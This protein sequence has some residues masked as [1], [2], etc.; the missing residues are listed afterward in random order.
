MKVKYEYKDG[1]IQ[2]G[3]ID[4]IFTVSYIQT[5]QHKFCNMISIFY[6]VFMIFQYLLHIN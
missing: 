4:G 3:I 2:S 5:D 1:L 6:L